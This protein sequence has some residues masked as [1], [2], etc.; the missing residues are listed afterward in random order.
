[1]VALSQILHHLFEGNLY[2]FGCQFSVTALGTDPGI[3]CHENL[4]FGVR[5]N[6]GADISAIH[7]DPLLFPHL[8]LQIDQL[9]ANCSNAA[10]STNVIAYF[11][12]ADLLLDILSIQVNVACS[13]LWIETECNIGLSKEVDELL[14]VD[15][16]GVNGTVAKS[17]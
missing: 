12:A 16:I 6:N 1:M 9:F 17:L 3:C 2:S 14:F 10:Y 15:M 8:L 13:T 11:N 7:D 5:E 4:Q